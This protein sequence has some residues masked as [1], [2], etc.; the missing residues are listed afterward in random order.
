VQADAETLNR[1]AVQQAVDHWNRGDLDQ[2]LR[3]YSDDVVLHV[4][5]GLE[6]G[7]ENV[8][9]FYDAWWQ[10]FP[11]SQLIVKDEIAAADKV[12]CRLVIEGRHAGSFQGIPPSGRPISVAGFTILRFVDGRCV[13]RWSVVDS[14]GLLTQIGGLGAP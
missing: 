13:E 7:L 6:P 8:R 1:R 10:A 9:R 2:Y 12:V 3:L 11:G 14:L 5:A 4:Y